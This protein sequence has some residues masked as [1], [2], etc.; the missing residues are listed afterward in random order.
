MDLI[1]DL[2]VCGLGDI[3]ATNGKPQPGQAIHIFLNC[4]PE[5]IRSP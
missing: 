3:D 1:F 5:A 2:E 4:L